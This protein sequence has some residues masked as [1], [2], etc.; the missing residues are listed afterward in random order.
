VGRRFWRPRRGDAKTKSASWGSNT[1][2]NCLGSQ[3]PPH[4]CPQACPRCDRQGRSYPGALGSISAEV[5]RLKLRITS[6][7]VWQ[8]CK[9]REFLGSRLLICSLPE[10]ASVSWS[11][12]SLAFR[13]LWY[14]TIVS[15]VTKTGTVVHDRFAAIVQLTIMHKQSPS[16]SRFFA[17]APT[18]S[19]LHCPLCDKR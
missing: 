1:T 9:P 16:P 2:L 19:M 10:K 12:V 18:S 8:F 14:L 7:R 6:N 11:S 5:E 4:Q 15:P 3:P 13:Y 17:R